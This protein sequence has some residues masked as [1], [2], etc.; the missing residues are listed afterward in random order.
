[1]S[2]AGEPF[3][4]IVLAEPNPN[5]PGL[6][7]SQLGQVPLPS[8]QSASDVHVLVD[9][10]EQVPAV[11]PVQQLYGLPA[12]THP[13]FDG[14]WGDSL[15]SPSKQPVP[16]GPLVASSRQKPQ[17][18]RAWLG[19]FAPVLLIVPVDRAK[20]IGRLPMLV[21]GI[22]GQSWL[23]GKLE[24]TGESAGTQVFPL[25]RPPWQTTG[26]PQVPPLG[27]SVVVLHGPAAFEPPLQVWLQTGHD[28]MPCAPDVG[29]S[30]KRS[31]PTK[32]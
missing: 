19:R 23:V 2:P 7:C 15:G 30:G 3:S 5:A 9:T 29:V 25:L 10:G 16:A 20:A 8:V 22:G 26:P 1:M 28:W 4:V 17:Y 27:Q 24:S 14:H 12:L 13:L 6:C 21:P 32:S 11:G 18:T 31:P